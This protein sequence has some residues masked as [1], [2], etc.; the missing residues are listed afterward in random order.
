V[1]SSAGRAPRGRRERRAHEHRHAETERVDWNRLFDDVGNEQRAQRALDDR[2]RVERTDVLEG[3]AFMLAPESD[4]ESDA[5]DAAKKALV[6][7]AFDL[8]FELV[9][10]RDLARDLFDAEWRAHVVEIFDRLVKHP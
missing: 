6:R 3:W 7:R 1:Y 5:C 10:A 4:E 2:H 8:R 9:I